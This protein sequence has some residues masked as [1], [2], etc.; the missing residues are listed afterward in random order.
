MSSFDELNDANRANFSNLNVVEHYRHAEGWL[1]LGE[2]QFFNRIADQVRNQ[3]VLDLG[4]GGGR[5]AWILR[6]LTSDYAGIDYSPAMVEVCRSEL[7]DLDIQIGDAR[8]LSRFPACRFKLI[9]FSYNGIDH[10]NHKDRLCILEEIHRVL[11]PGG[12]FLFSTLNLNSGKHGKNGDVPWRGS[13]LVKNHSHVMRIAI[14]LVYL[15][16]LLARFAR[17][18]LTWSRMK[19]HAEHHD[20]WSIAPLCDRGLGGGRWFLMHFTLPSAELDELNRIGFEAL[21][22]LSNTGHPVR[23]DEITCGYFHVLARKTID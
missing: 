22:V 1:D 2:R 16:K 15:P 11:Q 12:Y 4:V 14:M 5:T 17:D 19:K 23:S 13:F 10:V 8:D 6:L 21:E 18:V 7:P 3:P 20:S 9:L